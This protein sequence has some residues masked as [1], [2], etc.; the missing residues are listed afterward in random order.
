MDIVLND[1]RFIEFSGKQVVGKYEKDEDGNA[2]VFD[3]VNWK[4]SMSG[5]IHE[6]IKAYFTDDLHSTD[7]EGTATSVTASE[8][9]ARQKISAK[10]QL[11]IAKLAES[12]AEGYLRA[13]VFDE[14]SGNGK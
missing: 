1:L 9:T 7:I 14:L 8:L 12:R 3:Y 11:A 2:K 10:E 6:Y 4:G 5:T 13:E